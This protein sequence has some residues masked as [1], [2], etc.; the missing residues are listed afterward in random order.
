MRF[1]LGNCLAAAAMLASSMMLTGCISSTTVYDDDDPTIVKQTTKKSTTVVV[2]PQQYYYYPSCQAYRSC[3]TNLWYWQVKGVW[4][5]G[6]KLPKTIVIGNEVPYVV[7]LDAKEPKEHH[8]VIVKEY[9]PNREKSLPPQ[10][11]GKAKG[12]EKQNARAHPEAVSREL[13]DGEI[14]VEKSTSNGKSNDSDKADRDD[15]GDKSH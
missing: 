14:V 2:L 10:A 15:R 12:H 6:S 9:P 8:A 4:K 7:M 11:N 1:S 3:T 5:S 13:H